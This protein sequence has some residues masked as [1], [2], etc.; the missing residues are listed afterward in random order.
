MDKNIIIGGL[1]HDT[2]EDTKVT[3]DDIKNKYGNDILFL[4]E[5]V[6]N[7][8]GIK[9][10]SRNQQK[11]ENFMKMFLSFAKDIRAILIKLA[12][13]LHN[14]QTISYLPKMKQR[15]FAIESKEIFVP[16]AHRIGMN[17]IKME[18]EDIIFSILE[19][20]QFTKIKKL[21]KS[22][23]KDRTKY[24]SSFISPITKS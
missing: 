18:M 7:L 17:K 24:I 16:L 5:S 20:S 19:L 3:K 9:F 23:Q 1:L 6:T 12:D 11:A 2:I 22:S 21:V 13:R 8:S 14:L 15:R 4:V 10:N